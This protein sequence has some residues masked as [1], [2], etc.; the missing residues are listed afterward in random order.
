MPEPHGGVTI[1]AAAA[2]D[3]MIIRQM[4]R[5]AHL[6]PTD[7]HWSHFVVAAQGDEIV[8]IGQMRPYPRCRELG[9][10]LVREDMRRQGIARRIVE[11]LLERET[12]LVYLECRAEMFAYYRRFG[13][14]EMRWQDAPMPLKLKA[15]LNILVAGLFRVRGGVMV[16]QPP[17]VGA[18]PG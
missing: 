15:G 16:R 6:D 7:L 12:G 13:F 17:E 2:A 10:L 9:S 11:A 8:G 18:G 5:A 14:R 1:R 3:Q 4:V